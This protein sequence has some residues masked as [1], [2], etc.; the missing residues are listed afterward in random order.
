MSKISKIKKKPVNAFISLKIK[1]KHK[2][3][4][5]ASAKA[6]A[7][8]KSVVVH[9]AFDRYFDLKSDYDV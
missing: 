9:H 8:P 1:P 2:Q 3:L 5:E 4:I 7:V 6:N